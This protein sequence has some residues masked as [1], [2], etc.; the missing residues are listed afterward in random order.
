[1][2]SL[3]VETLNLVNTTEPFNTPSDLLKSLTRVTS[4]IANEQRCK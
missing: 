3:T 2:G 4:D 1:M